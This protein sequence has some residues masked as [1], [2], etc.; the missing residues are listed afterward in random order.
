MAAAGYPNF[1]GSLIPPKFKAQKKAVKLKNT[2][3]TK[4]KR[5]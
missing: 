4:K 2:K 5:K 3:P 1:S